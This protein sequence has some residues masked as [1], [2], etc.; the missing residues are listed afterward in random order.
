MIAC[1]PHERR[2]AARAKRLHTLLLVA[3]VLAVLAV[4]MIPQ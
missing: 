3:L 2:A 1:L 4:W